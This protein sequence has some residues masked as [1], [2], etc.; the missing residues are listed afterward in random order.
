VETPPG[1]ASTFELS[2]NY[3]N[4]FNPSTRIQFAVP[5]TEKV[6]LEVY[7]IQGRLIKTLVDYELY[8]PG[9]YEVSWNG[10]DNKGNRVASGVYFAKMQAGKFAHTKK[11]IM[12]K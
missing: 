6:K 1:S 3:P 7:D 12:N 11:M 5:Q 4:P 9:K 8:Q 2:Q 10:I